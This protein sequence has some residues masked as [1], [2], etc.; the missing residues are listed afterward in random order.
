VY[1]CVF[2]MCVVCVCVCFVCVCVCF[3][4]CV[5]YVCVVCVLCM[6]V[7]CVMRVCV[8]FVCCVCPHVFR[9]LCVL[10]Q[11]PLPPPLLWVSHGAADEI[12]APSL[13]RG[14]RAIPA[15]IG[16]ARCKSE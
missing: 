15:P 9:V 12:I 10:H 7:F 5:C 3:V 13:P 16:P 6:Y 14:R 8:C 11:A 2:R 4:L 1:V